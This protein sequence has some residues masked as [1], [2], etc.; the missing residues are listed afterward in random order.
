MNIVLNRII[1]CNLLLSNKGS[2][3]AKVSILIQ[4][5]WNRSNIVSE[6]WDCLNVDLNK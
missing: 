5:G 6:N 3:P 1:N 4:S 2:F